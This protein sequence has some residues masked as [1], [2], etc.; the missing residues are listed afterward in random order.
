MS[1]LSAI[2]SYDLRRR[3]SPPFHKLRVNSGFFKTRRVLKKPFR[4]TNRERGAGRYKGVRLFQNARNDNF[5]T[6]TLDLIEKAGF[7][8]ER[9]SLNAVRVLEFWNRLTL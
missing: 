5:G 8:P 2:A 3:F 7:K 1:R 4:F 6:A 9:S